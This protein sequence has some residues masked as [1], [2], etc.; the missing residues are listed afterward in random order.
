MRG[1]RR[2]AAGVLAL[3]AAV[4]LVA[5]FGL[6]SADEELPGWRVALTVVVLVV[7]IV[8][9]GDFINRRPRA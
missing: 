8:W 2:T 4:I 3:I 1:R 6:G 7:L 5:L 9:Y